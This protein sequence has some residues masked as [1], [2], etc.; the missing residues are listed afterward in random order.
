MSLVRNRIYAKSQ[1]AGDQLTIGC[2]RQKLE[3]GSQDLLL[4]LGYPVQRSNESEMIDI[5]FCMGSC[6][7]EPKTLRQKLVDEVFKA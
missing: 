5:G 1:T 4:E 7:K 3:I 2:A 6:A